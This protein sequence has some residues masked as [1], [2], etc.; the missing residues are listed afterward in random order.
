MIGCVPITRNF[1]TNIKD[2]GS[3]KKIFWFFTFNGTVQLKLEQDDPYN[4]ITHLDNLKSRSAK[5]N[6][7]M[8]SLEYFST[9]LY[10]FLH[11]FCCVQIQFGFFFS[12]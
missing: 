7:T 10:L 2:C 4:S 1:E 12:F 3:I 11:F 8:S 6:F 9:H 5:G